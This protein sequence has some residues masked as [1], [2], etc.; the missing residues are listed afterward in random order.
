MSGRLQ[1]LAPGFIANPAGELS[2]SVLLAGGFDS[3]SQLEIVTGRFD[4]LSDLQT[5]SVT[6]GKLLSS[7]LAKSGSL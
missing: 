1:D 7:G 4:D 3:L 2:V 6:D 5:A